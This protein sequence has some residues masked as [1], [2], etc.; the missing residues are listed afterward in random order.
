M[1]TYGGSGGISPPFFIS[2]LE[3]DE[4]SP[5]RTERVM[6]E[7]LTERYVVEIGCG[8]IWD[9]PSTPGIRWR[10]GRKPWK[11]T[12]RIT[13]IWSRNANSSTVRFGKYVLPLQDKR[14]SSLYDM[15][16]WHGSSIIKPTD[17]FT[18]YLSRYPKYSSPFIYIYIYIYSIYVSD[19]FIIL[20]QLMLYK[21]WMACEY[22]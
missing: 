15:F 8:L 17:N 5:P 19:F 13:A 7:W 4:G 21:F 22:K 2:T 9:A 3:G 12:L 6:V 14:I 18:F 11:P 1:K 16:P 20:Y 10:A